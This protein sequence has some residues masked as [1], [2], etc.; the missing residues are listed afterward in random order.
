MRAEIRARA[1][2]FVH[3]FA[4]WEIFLFG[5]NLKLGI[6]TNCNRCTNCRI[7]VSTRAPTFTFAHHFP[8]QKKPSRACR[9]PCQ[10]VM[11]ILSCNGLSRAEHADLI[12]LPRRARDGIT[13]D[14]VRRGVSARALR[15]F[16]QFSID[17]SR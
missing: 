5:T 6:T 15:V 7:H 13:F 3:I 10:C 2:L 4:L 17:L 14:L 11:L 12:R 1:E 9:R 16:T 8:L